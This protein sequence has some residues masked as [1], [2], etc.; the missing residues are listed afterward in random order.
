M[1]GRRSWSTSPSAARCTAEG[2]TSLDDWPMFTWSFGWTASPARLPM[3]SFAFMLD[4]VPEPVW[5]TSMG[6]WSSCSPAA[7]ASPPAAMRSATSWSRSPSAALARAAAALIRPSAR[8]T[9]VGTGFPE[10]GKF[11]TALSVSPPQS[12]SVICPPVGSSVGSEATQP[13][14]CPAA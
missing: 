3:T 5:K 9:G 10:T 2:N 7:T 4:E 13:E 11:A 12:L 8:I 6:N 14:A 1:A